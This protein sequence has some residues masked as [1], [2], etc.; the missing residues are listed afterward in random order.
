MEYKHIQIVNDIERIVHPRL[1]KNEYYIYVLENMGKRVKVGITHNIRNRIQSL[2]GS[3]NGGNPFIQCAISEPTQLY[4]LEHLIHNHFRE[5][6]IEGTEWF[7]GITF[8]EVTDY[9]EELFSSK[10]YERCQEER[11]KYNEKQAEEVPNEMEM[12]L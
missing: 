8:E 5:N 12:E 6:R 2:S 1:S 11:Q 7:Q 10:E 9:I 3:N 4:S